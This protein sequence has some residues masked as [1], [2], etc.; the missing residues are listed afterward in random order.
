MSDT[1]LIRTALLRVLEGQRKLADLYDRLPGSIDGVPQTVRGGEFAEIDIDLL[2]RVSNPE[3]GRHQS[4]EPIWGR[5]GGRKGDL[6]ITGHKVLDVYDTLE[7]L[8]RDRLE[9]K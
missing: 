8:I 2:H 5:V 1:E 4:T 3:S 6:R 7:E 9:K